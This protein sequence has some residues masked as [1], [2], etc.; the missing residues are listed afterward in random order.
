MVAFFQ[1]QADADSDAI[2]IALDGQDQFSGG[3]EDLT[4]RFKHIFCWEI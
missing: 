1:K 4:R 3:A 2:S